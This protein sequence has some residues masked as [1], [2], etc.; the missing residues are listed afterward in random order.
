MYAMADTPHACRHFRYAIDFISLRRAAAAAMLIRFTLMILADAAELM[1]CRYAAITIHAIVAIARAR[2]LRETITRCLRARSGEAV[3]CARRRLVC[4]S[5][6]AMARAR[7]G[8]DEDVAM[9]VIRKREREGQLRAMA[10][11]LCPGER[12]NDARVRPRRIHHGVC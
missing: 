7:Y 3:L 5:T 1:T 6:C 2:L 4:S 9:R 8:A 11:Q 12:E 10:R